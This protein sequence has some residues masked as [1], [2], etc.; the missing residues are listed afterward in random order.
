MADPSGSRASTRS[1]AQQGSHAA[2]FPRRTPGDPARPEANGT[3]PAPL[4]D[5]DAWPEML[6]RVL[7]GEGF[8][9]HFQP[10]VDLVRGAV[11]G[12][13]ALARFDGYPVTDPT[14]WFEA[15]NRL[16][17][18]AELQ[19]M[20]LRLALRARQDMPQDTFLAVNVGP[21]VLDDPAIEAVWD[22]QQDLEGL[23][24]ELTEHA[25]V[26]SYT[27]LQ[28]RL[29]R[30]RDAGALIALDDTG[31]GYAGLRHIIGIR[32]HVIKLD[33]YLIE[34]IDHDETKRALVEMIGSFANRVQAEVLAEGIEDGAE[35]RTVVA[36]GVTLAQGY[37]LARPEPPWVELAAGAHAQLLEHEPPP[38][39][40][41]VHQL[42]E[43][44]TVVSDRESARQVFA[45]RVREDATVVFVDSNSRPVA[46]VDA[47]GVHAASNPLH[48]TALDTT[49]ATAARRAVARFP[50]QRF[51]PV[52]CVDD[53]GRLVGVVRVERLVDYL[54]DASDQPHGRVD[55]RGRRV[56]G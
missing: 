13:E 42:V 8:G 15:A 22:E 12:Y 17:Q 50:E 47:E 34:G 40:D 16:G 48:H 2:R 20:A 29:D 28:P 46:T 21:E 18:G 19:S 3:R 35:L 36:L 54:A 4:V 39:P 56:G 31:A 41:T 30:L 24:V 52:M 26:A 43:S 53:D 45:Q 14:T 23:V 55:G 6:A 7:R 25:R 32:P 38:R 11:V 10:I 49:I 44:P 5:A 1:E 33:R 51:R 37:L 9:V 27:A